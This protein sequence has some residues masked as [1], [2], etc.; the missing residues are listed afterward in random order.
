MF[1]LECKAKKNSFFKYFKENI[2][3]LQ[4]LIFKNDL[5][6]SIIATLDVESVLMSLHLD[7]SITS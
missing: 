4:S 3:I 5:S 2:L 1:A 7:D 6:L